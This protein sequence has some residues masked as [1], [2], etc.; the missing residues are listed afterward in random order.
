VFAG[1]VVLLFRELTLPHGEY[2]DAIDQY[3]SIPIKKAQIP[4]RAYDKHTSAGKRRER[5]LEHFFKEGASVKNERFANDW[6]QTGKAAYFCAEQ[7][8]FENTKKLIEAINEKYKK[9]Q[10]QKRIYHPIT[11]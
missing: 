10:K 8:G 4:D 5:S 7:T 3:F 6:E 1:S 2:I 11:I 9:S